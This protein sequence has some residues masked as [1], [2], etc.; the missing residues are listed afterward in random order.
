MEH[1]FMLTY[2]MRISEFVLRFSFH[3][4]KSAIVLFPVP[5]RRDREDVG[6]ACLRLRPDGLELAL[7]DLD[8]EGL[9]E[10]L[11]L[12][13]FLVLELH[14]AVGGLQVRGLEGVPDPILG[15]VLC[16]A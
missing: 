2:G 9:V 8:R 13:A 15:P 1:L 10:V 14:R 11:V 7:L 12:V 6:L 5:P 4:P 3:N 16:P